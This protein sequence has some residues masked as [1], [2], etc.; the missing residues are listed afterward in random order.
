MLT[1]APRSAAP[2]AVGWTGALA[3]QVAGWLARG[4]LRRPAAVACSRP[5]GEIVDARVAVVSS[6]SRF[7]HARAPTASEECTGAAHTYWPCDKLNAFTLRMAAHGHCVNA[8]MMLGHRPYAHERLAAAGQIDDEDL[9]ELAQ[10]LQNFFD[11]SP[12]DAVQFL[13]AGLR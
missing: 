1:L 6:L 12:G 7:E 9:R 2:A 8:D 3:A 13:G 10:Q 4:A 11:A 5:A